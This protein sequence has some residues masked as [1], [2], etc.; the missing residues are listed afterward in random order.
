M[1]TNSVASPISAA[2]LE[3]LTLTVTWVRPGAAGISGT[4]SPAHINAMC[5]SQYAACFESNDE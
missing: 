1:T 3:R 5:C 4:A 2:P